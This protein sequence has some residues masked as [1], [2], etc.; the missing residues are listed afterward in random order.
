VGATEGG[1]DPASR[2]RRR[3]GG[4]A[5]DADAVP[6]DVALFPLASPLDG[7]E[8]LHASLCSVS[9]S[10]PCPPDKVVRILGVAFVFVPV[11]RE[12]DFPH[13]LR[14]CGRVFRTCTLFMK[15]YQFRFRSWPP[16][17]PA[18]PGMF[19]DQRQFVCPPLWEQCAK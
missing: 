5:R 10:A 8:E 13:K 16:C 2:A 19:T 1:T 4:R 14:S 7:N 18:L 3:D 11:H 17:G 9:S 15:N 6:H 12:A